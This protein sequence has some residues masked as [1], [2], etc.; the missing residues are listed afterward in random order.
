MVLSGVKAVM[1]NN[2]QRSDTSNEA[3]R[4]KTKHG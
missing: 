1:E 3:R 2:M 4:Y